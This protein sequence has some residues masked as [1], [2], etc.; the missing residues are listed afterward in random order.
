MRRL[1][2]TSA[3]VL[4]CGSAASAATLSVSADKLTYLVGE[5]ITLSIFGDAQGASA[6][7]IFGRL[8][9]NGGLVDL[10]DLAPA[11]NCAL[12]NPSC[13]SSQKVIGQ[14]WTKGSLE[15]T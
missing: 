15:A 8:G 5:T 9:F 3:L 10:T 1:L 6:D 14:Y 4:A 2:F 13:T 7:A 12:S 11:A